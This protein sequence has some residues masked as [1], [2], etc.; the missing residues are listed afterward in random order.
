L[1]KAPR[2]NGQ[3]SVL[4]EREQDMACSKC[5]GN[6][7]SCSGCAGSLELTRAEVAFLENLGQYSFLPIARKADDMTPIYLEEQEYTKEEY[8]LILQC[9]EKKG[10]VSLDYRAPLR[11]ADMQAYA[12]YPVHGSAALTE[13]GYAVLDLLEKQGIT[14]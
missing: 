7:A 13:R 6:C 4:Y 5:S 12:L 10:L 14:Q 9:L 11:G 1:K 8:S 3:G 2:P